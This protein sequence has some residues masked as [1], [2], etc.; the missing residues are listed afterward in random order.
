MTGILISDSYA[1]RSYVEIILKYGSYIDTVGGLSHFG[2]HMILQGSEK[3]GPIFPVFNYLDGI[4]SAEINAMTGGNSQMY[5]V[6]LPYNY[7][8]EKAIDILVDAFR[9]PLYLPDIVKNE[10]EAVNHEFYEKINSNIRERDIIRQ[11]ASPKTSYKGMSTG[12]N[13]TLKKVK[14]NYYL[15]N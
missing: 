10:I 8:Y 1:L 14:V 2:E 13:E 11:L 12:N 5:Y 7:Q 9:H 15:K 3:Y 4:Y 6:S